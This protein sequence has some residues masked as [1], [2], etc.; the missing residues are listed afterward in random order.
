MAQ[1]VVFVFSVT[2]TLTFDLCSIVCHTH[3]TWCTGI[4][5]RS[6]IRIRPVILGDMPW[7]HT[8][9]HT[10]TYTHTHTHTEGHSNSLT[11]CSTKYIRD[12]FRILIMALY[13]FTSNLMG[14][15]HGNVQISHSKPHRKSFIPKNDHTPVFQR[16]T[17][18][19]YSKELPYTP[20]FQRMTIHQYSKEW[21]YTSIPKNYHI[22]QYS[23]ELPYTPVFQRMT[24]H[25]YSK[26]LPYTSIPK[27]YRTPVF[28]ILPRG[29]MMIYYIL[30][31]KLTCRN[32][33]G[34]NIEVSLY[35]GRS[36]YLITS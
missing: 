30:C 6:F 17:I 8:H 23:K 25:Q 31:R 4:S 3:C 22:H 36:T 5:M 11:K 15:S 14:F 12:S 19:Q 18:H 16:M 10:H 1:I 28:S 29:H 7:T 21:P 34:C 24:I 27:N 20:V 2:L 9:T 35:V 32:I 33:E 26:E 13:V